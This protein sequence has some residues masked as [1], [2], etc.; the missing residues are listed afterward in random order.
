MQSCTQMR[1]TYLILSTAAIFF[2]QTYQHRSTWKKKK[3]TARW[4][5]V[6][7]DHNFTKLHIAVSFGSFLNLNSNSSYAGSQAGFRRPHSRHFVDSAATLHASSAAATTGKKH[8]LGWGVGGVWGASA[9]WGWQQKQPEPQHL[10]EMKWDCVSK[11]LI[12]ISAV[13]KCM[14][15]LL[16]LLLLLIIGITIHS[17]ERLCVHPKL[18]QSKNLKFPDADHILSSLG[19]RRLRFLIR[20]AWTKANKQTIRNTWHLSNWIQLMIDI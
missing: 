3:P 11:A 13:N 10:W 5:L 7:Y 9:K 18:T 2:L 14:E 15:P 4:S 20:G 19:D 8:L 17:L 6:L 1:V 16:L 12:Y